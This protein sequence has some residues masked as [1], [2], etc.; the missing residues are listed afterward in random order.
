MGVDNRRRWVVVQVEGGESEE[1][2]QTRIGQIEMVDWAFVRRR[3][4]LLLLT[5]AL[6][7]IKDNEKEEVMSFLLF[8]CSRGH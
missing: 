5:I 6:P 4:E 8:C 1:V 2:I 7:V 3:F